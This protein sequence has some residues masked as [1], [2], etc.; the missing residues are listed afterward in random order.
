[1]DTATDRESTVTRWLFLFYVPGKP[2]CRR[3]AIMFQT[4]AILMCPPDFYGIEYEINPWMSRS[5][6]SDPQQA[7]EQWQALRD[8][9]ESLGADIRQMTPIRGLPDLV[10]TANAGLIHRER[11][12]LS[13]FRHDARKGETA[14]DA[15]WFDANGLECVELPEGMAFEG[16]GD[17][18][19]VGETLFGGYIIRS[20]AAALQWVAGRINCRVIPLQLVD[21]RYYHLDTCFCPLDQSSAIV[22]LPAFDSYAQQ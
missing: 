7:T 21:T 12:Y 11:A 8:L 5:R 20:D 9:L 18:L 4:P 13:R 22:Y 14:Y 3:Q 15:E 19:F 10:F 16:A 6:G 1:M 17:A 2:A